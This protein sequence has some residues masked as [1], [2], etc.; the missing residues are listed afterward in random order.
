MFLLILCVIAAVLTVVIFF[1][2]LSQ[3]ATTGDG[4]ALD[5][6]SRV[7]LAWNATRFWVK[8]VLIPAVLI[9]FIMAGLAGF[10]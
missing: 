10:L 7:N 5:Q 3:S 1:Y 6:I 9:L 4:S 8:F 2:Y